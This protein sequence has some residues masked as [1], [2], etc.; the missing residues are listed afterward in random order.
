V[1]NDE[2]EM[3]S[4]GRQVTYLYATIPDHPRKPR[5]AEVFKDEDERNV[6]I[7]GIKKRKSEKCKR[8]IKRI[9]QMNHSTESTE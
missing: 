6:C 5:V 3:I 7:H 8:P 9:N 2:G 1:E 4:K